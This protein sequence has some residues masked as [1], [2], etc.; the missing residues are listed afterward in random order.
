M[1]NK[2]SVY[3]WNREH[4]LPYLHFTFYF[5]FIIRFWLSGIALI[6]I[7]SWIFDT[8]E[9]SWVKGYNVYLRAYELYLIGIRN[10][11]KHFCTI[12][13][14]SLAKSIQNRDHSHFSPS[15]TIYLTIP[16]H[17]SIMDS[18]PIFELL[19]LKGDFLEPPSSS[20]ITTP[21]YQLHPGLIDW[22]RIN[23]LGIGIRESLTTPPGV[24]TVMQW[25]DY[26][27]NA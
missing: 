19:A 15:T 4:A 23:P 1:V 18:T 10:V 9:Y 17:I 14:E 3:T 26:L 27:R 16:S 11:N 13:G 7:S 2:S 12:A 5:Y 25:L 20:P 22:F 6:H 8:L 21:S 24:R